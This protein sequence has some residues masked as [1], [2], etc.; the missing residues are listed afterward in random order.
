[1]AYGTSAYRILKA[2]TRDIKR[3]LKKR[4]K[5]KKKKRGDCFFEGLNPLV[6]KKPAETS[7]LCFVAHFSPLSLCLPPSEAVVRP[8]Y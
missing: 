5:E 2:T 6:K 8:F 7:Q 4:K 1:M 3:E